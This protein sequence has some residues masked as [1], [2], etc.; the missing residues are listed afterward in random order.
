[1]KVLNVTDLDR[2]VSTARQE[3]PDLLVI[4]SIQT[5]YRSEL[6]SLP[7]STQQVR[8]CAAV[9]QQLAKRED[10]TTLMIGRVTKEG[11]LAGPKILKHTGDTVLQF[12]R[13]Q[14][15]FHRILRRV[16]NRMSSAKEV[17]VCSTGEQ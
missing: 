14:S 2:I 11:E 10:I 4:D 7:G 1:M 9:L 15:R 6:A 13:D 8:E 16:K 5:I 3:K 17:G 12:A